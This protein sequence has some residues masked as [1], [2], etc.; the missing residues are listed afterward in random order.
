MLTWQGERA[1]EYT[2]EHT[3]TAVQVIQ[4]ETMLEEVRHREAEQRAVAEEA[5]T[6]VYVKEDT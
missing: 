3:E 4:L 5:K 6:C 2:T 1:S